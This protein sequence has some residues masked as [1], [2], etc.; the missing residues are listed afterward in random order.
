MYCRCSLEEDESN[1]NNAEKNTDSPD[2]EPIIMPYVYWY[3][4]N[5]LAAMNISMKL[6]F[7]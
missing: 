5:E 3:L 2:I 6:E 4:T 7:K 1:E